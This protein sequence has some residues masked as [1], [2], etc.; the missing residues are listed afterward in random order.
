MKRRRGFNYALL[1]AVAAV[2]GLFILRAVFAP[3]ESLRADFLSNRY[4]YAYIF[5]ATAAT[6]LVLGYV[7]GRQA[8]RLRHASTTDPLTGLP[9]RRAM[10]DRLR[11]EWQRA[12]RYD[13]PLALLL[14]DIDGLKR[15]ND[16]HG[17]N[18]G[19][20]LLRSTATAIRQTLRATDFGARWGGDEFSIIA[21]QTTPEAAQRLAERLLL[22]LADQDGRLGGTTASVGVAVFEA[23]DAAENNGDARGAEWLMRAADRALYAA[24]SAGRNRVKV[25]EAVDHRRTRSR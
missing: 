15:I 20:R 25:S 18:E 8:D 22:H 3:G 1:A 17:H 14:I 13:S 9:N 2:S 21:P 23:D 6:F 4:T 11:S 7:L 24:K 5:A 19:D 16:E 12:A 10:N